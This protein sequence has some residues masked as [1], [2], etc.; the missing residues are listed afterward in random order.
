MS[1]SHLTHIFFT[2]TV[3]LSKILTANQHT[4]KAQCPSPKIR[5]SACSTIIGKSARRLRLACSSKLSIKAEKCTYFPH[6]FL[7]QL[8]QRRAFTPPSHDYEGTHNVHIRIENTHGR[9]DFDAS[10]APSNGWQLG[11]WILVAGAAYWYRNEIKIVARGVIAGAYLAI[12]KWE[13]QH[14]SKAAKPSP[15]ADIGEFTTSDTQQRKTNNNSTQTST[16]LQ[17]QGGSI[18]DHI[19]KVRTAT[20]INMPSTSRPSNNHCS[21]PTSPHLTKATPSSPP[22]ET[23]QRTPPTTPSLSKAN[24]ASPITTP[25]QRTNTSYSEAFGYTTSPG[26]PG[27]ASTVS[28]PPHRTNTTYSAAFDWV[29]ETVEEH[30]APESAGSVCQ[31]YLYGNGCGREM[32]Q[33]CKGRRAE[34]GRMSFFV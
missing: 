20:P 1:Q 16:G 2:T 21:P 17:V 15:P 18:L 13:E 6:W 22:S 24:L 33:E 32:C 11:K 10:S 25:P 19:T 3:Q 26:N 27:N 28:K 8:T 4:H 23:S 12:S 7:A 14:A 31:E 30:E 9:V 29:P 5:S 34:E